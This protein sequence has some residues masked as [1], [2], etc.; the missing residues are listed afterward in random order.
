MFIG[1]DGGGTKTAFIIIDQ[2]GTI[3]ARHIE[4]TCSYLAIGIENTRQVLENG[5][6]V[7]LDKS[8]L[9][10]S[11]IKYAFFG[12]PSFGE[13]KKM[14]A[15]LADIPSSMFQKDT[16]SC[17][18]DTICGWAG[19]LSCAD[20]INIVAGTGSISYGEYKGKWARVGGWG[21]L[22]GD[23]GSAY[24]I[25]CDGLNLF[26]KMSDGRLKKGPLYEILRTRLSLKADLDLPGIIL[27]DWGGNR[28][29]I[30][31][32]SR[33]MSDAAHAGD[34]HVISIFSN[35]GYEL[36]Q[37]IDA[38]RRKLAFPSTMR[39][40]YSYS[41]GVFKA[42]DLILNP[43]KNALESE[44]EIVKPRFS[45]MV[46]AALYAAKLSGQPFDEKTLSSI[47]KQELDCGS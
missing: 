25:A 6:K 28:S 41:G 43:I 7:L 29:K 2:S 18:N 16:Y 20:G 35:A 4:G 27:D 11:D 31:S 26:T 42:G 30:A 46:G 37:I 34:D 1:V 14:E 5:I 32:L 36:A 8:D 33:L 38:T 21:E 19:S 44:Y 22:F 13:D 40:K 39:I 15:V 47:E 17:R 10:T 45:P 3:K 9:Q 23:E 12:L 24:K